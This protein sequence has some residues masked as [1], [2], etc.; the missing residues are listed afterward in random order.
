MRYGLAGENFIS[1]KLICTIFNQRVRIVRFGI[2]VDTRIMD[3]RGLQLSDVRP[4]FNRLFLG[5]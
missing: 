4:L 5:V 3:R 2:D 1:D